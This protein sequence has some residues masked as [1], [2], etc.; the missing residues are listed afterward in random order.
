LAEA[1]PDTVVNGESVPEL[2]VPAARLA[3]ALATG[4]HDVTVYLPGP[5]KKRSE[6]MSPRGHR[7]VRLPGGWAK[8]APQHKLGDFT[9]HLQQAWQ[10]DR[11]D[12]VHAQSWL[13]GMAAQSA[14]R[15]QGI[16]VV[17]SFDSVSG[18]HAPGT[19]AGDVYKLVSVLARRASW[20]AANNTEELFELLR[21]GCVRSRVSVIPAGVDSEVFTP[22]GPAAA[23]TGRPH[24]MVSVWTATSEFDIDTVTQALVVLPDAELVLAVDPVSADVADVRS[25]LKQAAERTGVA[26]RVEIHEVNNAGELAELLRSAD[27][28]ACPAISEPTG[29]GALMA[30]SCGVPVVGT[31]VGA[32][33]DVVVDEVTGRLVPPRDVMRFAE[34]AR[35]LLHEPFAGR[36]MGAAGRD[37]AKSRYSWDR[38]AADA[39]RAYD[40]AARTAGVVSA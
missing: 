27:V 33:V 18:G 30:M 8:G 22:P 2:A 3:T 32:L 36:G 9:T 40:G 21:T 26:D 25:R 15:S 4:G 37:R 14:A 12:V 35:R 7:V 5:E 16:P 17:Q 31:A 11:P 24:R 20:V 13:S 34:A 10:R 28:F 6:V 38:V 39:N 1:V 23:R 29:V 19:E